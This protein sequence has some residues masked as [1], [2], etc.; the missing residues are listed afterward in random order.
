M[1]EPIPNLPENALGFSAH[2][3]VTGSDYKDILIPAV[4]EKLV[5]FPKIR[6]L[7]HLGEDF[8]GCSAAAIWDDTK[9]G[10]KH[11]LAWKRCAIVTDVAWIRIITKIFRLFFP[12]DF[13]LFHNNQF[14]NAFDWICK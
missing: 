2:G 8:S 1:L 10:L 3:I 9:I 6:F 7:Y 13:R 5:R 11:P 12:G 4:E 14:Q